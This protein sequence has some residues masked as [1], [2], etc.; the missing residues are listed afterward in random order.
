MRT[1]ICK[2]IVFLSFW[3]TLCGIMVAINLCCVIGD[4]NKSVQDEIKQIDNWGTTIDNSTIGLTK[5]GKNNNRNE[6]LHE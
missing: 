6:K 4:V 5:A 1:K 2:Y 3:I